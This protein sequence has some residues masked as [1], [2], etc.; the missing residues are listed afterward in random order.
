MSDERDLLYEHF[1]SPKLEELFLSPKYGFMGLQRLYKAAKEFNIPRQYVKKW[2]DEQSVNQI[3]LH[4]RPKIVYHKIIGD[5]NSYQ[6]DIIF[7]PYPRLNGGYIG[8]MTFIN[9]STRMAHIA[10]IKSRKTEEILPH[11]AFILDQIELKHGKINSIAT[12]NEFY[13][14]REITRFLEEREIEHFVELA[15]IHSKL[16]IINRFHRTLRAMLN[17]V[18][19]HITL[20]NG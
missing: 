9:T 14:N 20:V 13:N 16:G 1:I 7:L 12:D 5:G 18:M 19:T 3:L 10:P 4:R 8:L 15:G 11:F 17:K 2:Y 6:A